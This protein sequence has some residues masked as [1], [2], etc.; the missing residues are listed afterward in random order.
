MGKNRRIRHHVNPLQSKLLGVLPTDQPPLFGTI[1]QPIE[2]ELGCAE[3]VFLF[4][5][6][7]VRPEA[8]FVGIEIRNDLV[9]RVNRWAQEKMC[10][11]VY[12]VFAH[13]NYD[14]PALFRP[15]QIE[16]AFINF[17]DPWFKKDQHKR[18]VVKPELAQEL[19]ELL[20]PSGELFFQ[21]DVFDLALDA[22]SVF[23]QTPGLMNVYG[24]WSFAKTNPYH[25]RS[26]REIRVE[27]K[28]LPIWRILY[29]VI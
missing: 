29:K 20:A 1:S 7:A 27:E 24:E 12:A 2:V 25:A 16:K 21:S 8:F 19:V 26:L 3:A 18:R 6:A 9:R 22:M 14:L 11:Q 28:G 13:L 23:E 10:P 5:R 4:E 15:K 17:P